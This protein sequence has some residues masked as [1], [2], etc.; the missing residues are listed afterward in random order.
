MTTRPRIPHKAGINKAGISSGSS[1]LEDKI[2][3]ES[4]RPKGVASPYRLTI[5]DPLVTTRLNLLY[6]F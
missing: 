2:K 5:I 6:V 3:R 1:R 4:I